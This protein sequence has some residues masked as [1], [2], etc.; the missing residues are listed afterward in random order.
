MNTWGIPS[1]TFLVIYGCVLAVTAAIVWL[2][3]RR[4]LERAGRDGL[5]ALGAPEIDP[6][7]AAMLTGG[8]KLVLATAV[9]RLSEAGS[10]RT[11]DGTSALERSGALPE[12]PTPVEQWVYSNVERDEP[13][14]LLDVDAAEPVLSGMRER[15]WALG[16]LLERP[17]AR[18][19]R[20]L[21]VRFLPAAG[22]GAARLIAGLHNHRPVGFLVLLMGVGA[23]TAYKLTE[24]PLTTAAGRQLLK[25]LEADHGAFGA[26]GFAG[27]VALSGF[28][29]LWAADATLA[30][31]LGLKQGA[32][33]TGGGG[34]CGGGGGGCGG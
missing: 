20:S 13:K 29:A 10:L 19:L 8:E 26:Y 34:G 30:T 12:R 18:Q 4:I 28:A 7:E 14:A 23:Y 5:V 22:L 31:T 9:C 6:Y 24:P 17:Q 11:V 32:D 21:L 15:L 3:R 27:D 25:R 1:G 2:F 16:L 33:G